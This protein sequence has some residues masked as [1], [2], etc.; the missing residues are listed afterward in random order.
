ME[1]KYTGI[2]LSKFDVGEAD[3]LYVIYTREIGKIRAKAVGVRKPG[4]KLAASLENF[5]LSDITVVKK[6]GIGKITGSIVE[7]SFPNIKNNLD[8]LAAVFEALKIF[9]RLISQEEKDEKVFALLLEFLEALDAIKNGG[10]EKVEILNQG[11]IFKLLDSLG[12][13][14]EASICASCGLRFSGEDNYFSAP[15]GGIV[16]H[17]CARESGDVFQASIN[18]IK[19]IRIFFSNNLKSF[20]KIK[21]GEKEIKELKTISKI[22]L[23]WL[24]K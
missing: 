8:A 18:T 22:F 24:G 21:T 3:R 12:Y 2:I 19:L 9:D 16:C 7:N 10:K 4:A 14:I 17:D 11:F 23:D 15:H 13:K 1:Y 20:L 5:T 6:Q